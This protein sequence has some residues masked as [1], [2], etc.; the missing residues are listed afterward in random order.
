MVSQKNVVSKTHNTSKYDLPTLLQL[1]SRDAICFSGTRTYAH[2]VKMGYSG[3]DDE[4]AV[5]R[6]IALL[7]PTHFHR[8]ETYVGFEVWHDIYKIIHKAPNGTVYPMY[9][10]L[11]L[12]PTGALVVMCSFHPEGWE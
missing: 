10:K 7:T 6:V 4:A 2:L 11:R 12:S 3:K 9:V 8:S 5:C 1:A